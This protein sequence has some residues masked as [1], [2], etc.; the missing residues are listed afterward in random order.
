FEEKALER[1]H[2]LIAHGEKHLNDKCTI[3]YFAVSLPDLAIWE[4]DLNKRN[5]IHCHYVMALGYLGMNESEKANENI[6]K[7][8]MLDVNHVSL[9]QEMS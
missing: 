8:L 7:V 2:T 4:E 6:N 5:C 9:I 3:D 1:F